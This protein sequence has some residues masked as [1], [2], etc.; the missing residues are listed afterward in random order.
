MVGDS[1]QDS[2]S[3]LFAA[4]LARRPSKDEVAVASRL[5]QA[6]KGN[7]KEMLQDMW[8]AILNSNEFI[9]QH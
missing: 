6:R 5:L 2:L 7:K 8:W 4:G 1:P 9:M 3:E